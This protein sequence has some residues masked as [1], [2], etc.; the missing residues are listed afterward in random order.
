MALILSK[1]GKA[2]MNIVHRDGMSIGFSATKIVIA[3]CKAS[4]RCRE[5]ELRSQ[6]S[7][8]EEILYRLLTEECGGPAREESQWEAIEEISLLLESTSRELQLILIEKRRIDKEDCCRIKHLLLD[9]LRRLGRSR[10][11]RFATDMI[12]MTMPTP[13]TV[14]TVFDSLCCGRTAYVG[15]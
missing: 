11:M 10:S 8:Y 4:L 12:L 7:V 6:H 5:K 14:E 3:V 9:Q 13:P 1:G 2:A 15:V